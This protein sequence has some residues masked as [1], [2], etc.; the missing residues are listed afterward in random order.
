MNDVINGKNLIDKDDNY[1]VEW[2]YMSSQEREIALKHLVTNLKRYAQ[3]DIN[4]I[5]K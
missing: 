5:T 1:I 4:L 2:Y 3:H